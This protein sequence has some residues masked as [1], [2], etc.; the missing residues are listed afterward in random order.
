MKISCLK[1][2][3]WRDCPPEVRHRYFQSEL[4]WFW[5]DVED[6]GGGWRQ[7]HRKLRFIGCQRL[8]NPQL[9]FLPFFVFPISNHGSVCLISSKTVNLD[10]IQSATRWKIRS[11]RGSARSSDNLL[12]GQA[13]P[14]VLISSES[15]IH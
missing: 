12:F 9:A 15:L 6:D 3:S 8:M 14:D 7:R 5:N 13:S 1:E 10:N 4:D 11:S 2:R